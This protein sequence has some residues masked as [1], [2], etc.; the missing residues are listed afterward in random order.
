MTAEQGALDSPPLFP[1][2]VPVEFVG[3]TVADTG[4]LVSQADRTTSL[5]AAYR[6]MFV[7]GNRGVPEQRTCLVND[8]AHYGVVLVSPGKARDAVKWAA[9][10]V[11]RATEEL[12][13]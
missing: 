10:L 1:A 3:V 13:R 5:T 12:Q 7:Q 4:A 8:A 2:A 6:K 9:Q 11:A